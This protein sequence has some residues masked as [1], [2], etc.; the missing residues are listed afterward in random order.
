MR[1]LDQ[2]LLAWL[3]TRL[4]DHNLVTPRNLSL[5]QH[6]AQRGCP[7]SFEWLHANGAKLSGPYAHC[8]LFHL[9]IVSYRNF[10]LYF[11]EFA[12]FTRKLQE[13]ED[14]LVYMLVNCMSGMTPEDHE[15]LWRCY[16][17]TDLEDATA[18]VWATN[19][20][21]GSAARTTTCMLTR[22]GLVH[23]VLCGPMPDSILLAF[24][25]LI[26]EHPDPVLDARHTQLME[27][28]QLHKEYHA[29][30]THQPGGALAQVLRTEI[31]LADEL[32]ELVAGYAHV[33][34]T[35]GEWYLACPLPKDTSNL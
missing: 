24:E 11:K 29:Q 2:N 30:Q 34:P 5:I 28:Q 35:A 3:E 4:I 14:L 32:C 31:P 6:A 25:K 26:E 21:A 18:I 23:S 7:C 20:A 13:Y 16:F 33:P 1:G 17:P 19:G 9:A 27:L 10:I 12:G 22:V 8:S 15:L